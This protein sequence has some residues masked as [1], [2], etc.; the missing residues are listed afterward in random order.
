M[1]DADLLTDAEIL[2]QQQGVAASIIERIIAEL[3]RRYGGDR[4]Y[5]QRLERQHRN[6]A[7]ATDL[8]NGLPVETVAKRRGCSISTVRR[9]SRN[10]WPL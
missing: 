6:E 9:A 8:S 7:I 3:R 2:L 1:P 4:H 10:E 5:I